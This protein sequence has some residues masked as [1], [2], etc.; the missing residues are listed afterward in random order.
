[1]HQ[2]REGHNGVAVSSPYD[3]IYFQPP[4]EIAGAAA[5]AYEERIV[6]LLLRDGAGLKE[7]ELRGDRPETKIVLR[8]LEASDGRVHDYQFELW[9]SEYPTSGAAEFGSLHDAASVA[10]WIY[11]DWMAGSLDPL[12]EDDGR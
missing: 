1:M 2:W 12:A 8:F 6:S 9:K 7:A 4:A 10:G 5:R 11:S 3:D